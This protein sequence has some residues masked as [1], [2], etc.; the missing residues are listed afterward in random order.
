MVA[1]HKRYP[2]SRCRHNGKQTESVS[3]TRRYRLGLDVHT[4]ASPY[5]GSQPRASKQPL[6]RE[7][8]SVAASACHVWGYGMINRPLQMAPPGRKGE[9]LCSPCPAPIVPPSS[10]LHSPSALPAGPPRWPPTTRSCSPQYAWF[11][12]G[13]QQRPVLAMR[14]H[15]PH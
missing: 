10:D 3:H 6:T 11:M 13:F 1:W 15:D 4:Q 12:K 7:H 9:E 8:T 2:G 14:L 5:L